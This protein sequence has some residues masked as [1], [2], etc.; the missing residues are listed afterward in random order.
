[1]NIEMSYSYKSIIDGGADSENIYYNATIINNQQQDS[2]SVTYPV[3]SFNES[4]DAPIIRDASQYNFSI[5]RFSMN[6][7][8]KTL[9]LFIPLIQTNGFL[10][11]IQNDPNRTIY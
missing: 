9:P 1:M 5:V 11:P 2:L 10:Y 6:G 4:R 7:P 8:N 3:V